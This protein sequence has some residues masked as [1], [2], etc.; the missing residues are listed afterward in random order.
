MGYGNTVGIN[1]QGQ[2]MI[3]P[4][5]WFGDFETGDVRMIEQRAL[6]TEERW[7]RYSRYE[8]VADAIQSMV[9]RGAPA[10]G[11]AAAMGIALAART[12]ADAPDYDS[13][14]RA[15]GAAAKRLSETRP[16]AVNLFWALERMQRVTQDASTSLSLAELPLRLHAEALAIHEEDVAMNRAL[17]RHGASLMPEGAQILTH[18]NTGSLATGGYG[19]ALGVIRAAFEADPGIHVWVDETRPYLQGA[20]LTAWELVKEGIP[21]TLITDSMAGFFMQQGE[22]DAVIIGADRIVANGDT[23][24]KIGSYSLAVLCKHHN[25]PFYVAAPSSTIDHA[26][27]TGASIPIEERSAEEVTHVLGKAV[28]APADIA[29]RHPAF[30]VTPAALISAIITER[31]V[32]RAPYT[33]SLRFTS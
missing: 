28:I 26:L 6:P 29:V 17:G 9:I 24:N 10:I 7:H 21:A 19:T 30:D 20:R 13:F 11:I 2:D 1:T 27:E 8:E 3:R 18:C 22:V 15:I 16:T 14:A 12:H 32:H 31:G 23:A 25:I 33:E 4:I 5:E